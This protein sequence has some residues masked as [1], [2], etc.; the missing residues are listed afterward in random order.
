MNTKG[1][2]PI[3]KSSSLES[4]IRPYKEGL[5]FD[6]LD[7]WLTTLQ[8][9]RYLGISENALRILVFRKKIKAYKFKRRL[10][11]KLVDLKDC[12]QERN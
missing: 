1:L 4:T 11:F 12:F 5:F 10:R 8:A 7:S 2:K 6:N 9:S 3:K